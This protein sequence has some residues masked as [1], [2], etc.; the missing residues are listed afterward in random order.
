MSAGGLT[1]RTA[2]LVL[3]VVVPAE[4]TAAQRSTV[5]TDSLRSP[6]PSVRTA[7][8]WTAIPDIDGAGEDLWRLAQL[9][10]A[11]SAGS[12]LRTPSSMMQ[13]LGES[14]PRM[15]F[16]GARWAFVTPQV[17]Y[18]HNSS[19]PFSM[20][21]GAMWAG[22]GGT[23]A[24][25]GGVRLQWN[26]VQVALAPQFIDE[27]NL[28]LPF[29][30]NLQSGLP[31]LLPNY[32]SPYSTLWNIFPNGADIPFRFGDTRHSYGDW[33]QSFA[34]V[35]FGALSA[36]VSTENEWWGPGIQNALILSNNAP[37]V[38]RLFVRTGR[39]LTTGV[40]EFEFSTFLG[41]LEESDYF[42]TSNAAD[43]PAAFD[44]IGTRSRLLAS[45]ALVWR[46]K[47]EPD[48]ALGLARSVF[49]E[50]VYR[51]PLLLRWFDVFSNVGQPD[52]KPVTDSTATL[53]RDQLMSLFGRWVLPN[54]GFEVYF[55]WLRASMP[56]SLRDFLTD[57]SHSRGFTLGLQWLALANA[58]GAS[59]RL[60][61]ELTNLEQDESTNYRSIGSIYTSR[62][63]P[64]GY[65]QRGQP[66]GAAFGPGSSSQFVAADYLTA[67]WSLGMFGE[68]VRWNEDAHQLT[69]YPSFKGWCESDVSL[70]GGLRGRWIG[71][72][73]AINASIATAHRYNVFFQMFAACPLM[74]TDPG[75]VVDLRNATLN[76]SFEPL[77]R[78]LW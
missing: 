55:E 65:T 33:G 26:R 41:K 61:G 17:E 35:R 56:V 44:H 5:G 53:G 3:L 74:P 42:R 76:L 37:G 69:P 38:P 24:V 20:N 75:R 21:D 51:G 14:A 67:R 46:P 15:H 63:V 23:V 22:K 40:G 6:V 78:R 47:W 64:Q 72:L 4:R 30:D 19:V 45:A 43:D 62:V 60:Q 59:L 16:L 32:R 9:R 68:R 66:L 18:T 48:L 28:A 2:L 29:F 49:A 54:D 25:G 39:P 8:P 31:Y 13:P 58:R 10:G 70:I 7:L 50:R 71:R 12:L 36:G 1:R 73:G 27:E 57:P 34:S 11:S 52:D 77:V